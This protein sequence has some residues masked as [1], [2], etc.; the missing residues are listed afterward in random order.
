M[1]KLICS[2]AIEGAIGWVAKAEAKLDEAIAAKG[3]S[4]AVGFPDTAYF[5]PVI[6]SFTGEK[7][8]TLADLRRILKRAKELLRTTALRSADIAY[9]VGYSDPHYFS[10]AFKKHTGLSPTEFRQQA[11]AD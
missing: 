1:S 3:E 6:Y 5:L 2:S 4:C 8:Q 10:A 11:Q 7:M 9:Q